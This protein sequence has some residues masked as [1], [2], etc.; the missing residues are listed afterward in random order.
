M[1]NLQEIW[2]D[3]PEYEGRYQVSNLGRVRSLDMVVKASVGTRVMKGRIRKQSL[4]GNGYYYLAL[5]FSDS[6]YKQFYIHRLVASVFINKPK[7]KYQVNHINGV[8][9]DNRVDNLEWCT[10]LENVRHA[11]SG[12]LVRIAKGESKANC[13]LS[14]DQ[15]KEIKELS[16]TKTT[17]E[18]RIMLGYPREKRHLI[19]NI[20]C[21]RI[22]KHI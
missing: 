17:E 12:G 15:A 22:W 20:K 18:I 6:T 2:K 13:V 11:F 19:A 10:A 3:I 5:Y 7:P 21:G 14:E 4:L 16:K 9:T 8:K 1:T